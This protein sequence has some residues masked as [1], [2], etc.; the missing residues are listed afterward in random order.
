MGSLSAWQHIAFFFHVQH[1]GGQFFFPWASS[2]I[3]LE[4]AMCCV[5]FCEQVVRRSCEVNTY[6]GAR[7]WTN[8]VTNPLHLIGDSL[9]I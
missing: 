6:R 1:C 5:M 7:F 2:F 3:Y 9:P 8:Q 4:I